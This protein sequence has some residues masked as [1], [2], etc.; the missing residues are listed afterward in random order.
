[1]SVSSYSEEN[2]FFIKAISEQVIQRR[3]DH[4]KASYTLHEQQIVKQRLIH[5][6][7]QADASTPPDP[8]SNPKPTQPVESH[9]NRITGTGKKTTIRPPFRKKTP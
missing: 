7:Y 5:V 6:P 4:P 9:G 8:K 1:M 3:R 2:K